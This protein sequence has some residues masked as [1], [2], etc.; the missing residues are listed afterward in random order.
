MIDKILTKQTLIN[1]F[2]PLNL[3]NDT[4]QLWENLM[5]SER[6][7]YIEYHRLYR[8]TYFWRTVRQQEIDYPEEYDGRLY[9]YEFKWKAKNKVK[10]PTAFLKTYPDAEFRVID[11]DNYLE[12]LR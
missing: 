1:Q 10:V 8:N 5:I 3:R 12:F 9:A 11:Q 4:G 6:M 7:K 2:N